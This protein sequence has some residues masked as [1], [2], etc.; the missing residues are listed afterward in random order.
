MAVIQDA[1]DVSFP[2]FDEFASSDRAINVYSYV[3]KL[4]LSIIWR[5]VFNQDLK[6]FESATTPPASPI[7]YFGS[8]LS[9]ARKFSMQP[10]WFKYLPF[11]EHA[12][13]KA[14][15]MGFFRTMAI[16]G[17]G[18]IRE[19]RVPSKRRTFPVLPRRVGM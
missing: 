2:V 1:L 18:S 19:R 17:E 13:L 8:F 3:F 6:H 9:T 14:L 10:K 12:K 4:A 15:C 5:V 11:S 16:G 7:R